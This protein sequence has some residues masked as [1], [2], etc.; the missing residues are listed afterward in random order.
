M[1]GGGGGGGG[2]RRYRIEGEGLVY[3]DMLGFVGDIIH[4]RL[5]IYAV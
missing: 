4:M 3:S 1:Y 2:R 5:Y